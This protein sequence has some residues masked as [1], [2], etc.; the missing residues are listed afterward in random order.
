MLS[1][2]GGFAGA[3]GEAGPGETFFGDGDDLVFDLGRKYWTFFLRFGVYAAPLKCMGGGLLL[4][5]GLSM[6]SRVVSG[7]W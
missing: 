1:G 3:P 4:L 7:E 2:D 6:V 5:L